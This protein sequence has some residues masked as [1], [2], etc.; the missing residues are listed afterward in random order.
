MQPGGLKNKLSLAVVAIIAVLGL[1]AT[2]M[3]YRYASQEFLEYEKGEVEL[4]AT[5]KSNQINSIMNYGFAAVTTLGSHQAVADFV[6]GADGRITQEQMLNQL[7]DANIADLFSAIY[8]M[9]ETGLTLVS[10]D[11]RFTGNNYGFRTYFETAKN[12][13]VSVDVA[14]GV[15]SQKI[16][17][18]F[19]SPIY[20]SAGEFAGVVVAKLE[21]DALGGVLALPSVMQHAHIMFVDRFGVIVYSGNTEH[22]LMALSELDDDQ[23]AEIDEKRYYEG[24]MLASM[25]L[26]QIA[27]SLFIQDY[28]LIKSV[29]SATGEEFIIG[30]DRIGDTSFHLLIMEETEHYLVAVR[31]LAY[32]ISLFVLLAAVLAALIISGIIS[33]FL[34]PLDKLRIAAQRI[35]AGDFSQSV[36]IEQKNELGLLAQAFNRMMSSL[37]SEKERVDQQISVQTEQLRSQTGELEQRQAA[38]MNVLE[39][40][41][42]E[43]NKTQQVAQDLR[44]F[45]MAVDG[46]SDHVV[47]TDPN[48]VVL[49]A[50]PAV[51]RITGFSIEEVV[52]KK[53]GIKMMWGG[54]MDL[55]F[56]KKL[57]DTIKIQKRVFV[58]EILNKR[59]NG[60]LYE[61]AVTITPI[62]D[63]KNNVIFFLGIERDITIEKN[64]ERAKSDFVSLASHQLRTPLTAIRWYLDLMLEG[65]VGKMTEEQLDYLNTIKVSNIRMVNLV[66]SLLNVSRLE[67]GTFSVD[68]EPVD[69]IKMIKSELEELGVQIRTKRLTLAENYDQTIGEL[70]LDVNLSSIV[71]QN[72]IS[73]AV[74]YTKDEGEIYID[75]YQ[76][77][78]KGNPSKSPTHVIFKVRD[79]GEGI[80]QSDQHRIFEKMFR[81][82]N[83]RTIDPEGNGLGLYMV[84]KVI[85]ETGGRI[86]FESKENEGT[87][88]YVAI[89]KKGM[90]RREGTKRL[91]SEVVKSNGIKPASD[92]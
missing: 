6:T 11:E 36:D 9:D 58:G 87:T 69:L 75:L 60:D 37:I 18:Y 57:W 27:D 53:V 67:L 47:L 74:K 77:T 54:L 88:F 56:Y 2:L 17:F 34:S 40:V 31:N 92:K 23:L 83:A 62:L 71:V 89:P 65:D 24:A 84:K 16:G 35:T 76:G 63:E 29:E 28:Y 4:T 49:Y 33:R 91:A 12:G 45:K 90:K 20:D 26:D 22:E 14:L 64:I 61:A 39:D 78:Q 10:T 3:V 52:G 82:D 68:P 73:N 30:I 81:A 72:I 25:G 50:N 70:S 42:D 7:I 79:T 43:K 51:K 32:L 66:N 86:W 44:K 21:P 8:I 80:P 1:A 38:M 48:G 85:E 41:A 15:T 46:T 19:S 55:G 13:E 5:E 59:K